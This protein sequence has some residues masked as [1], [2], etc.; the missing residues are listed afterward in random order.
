[1]RDG[2]EVQVRLDH[3]HVERQALHVD[4]EQRLNVRLLG[5]MSL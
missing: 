2:R 5:Y 1:L 4:T 3:L